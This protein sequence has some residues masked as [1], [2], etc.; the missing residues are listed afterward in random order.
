MSAALERARRDGGIGRFR[1]APGPVA[2]TLIERGNS[3]RASRRAPSVSTE[4]G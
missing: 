4:P 1:G 2:G 3:G